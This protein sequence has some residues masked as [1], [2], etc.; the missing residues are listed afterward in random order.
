M[1]AH[2]GPTPRGLTHA[3][4]GGGN[5]V[6]QLDRPREIPRAVDAEVDMQ[7]IARVELEK[8]VLADGVRAND[9]VAVDQ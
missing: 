5:G 7:R 2:H 8:Q 9:C 4:T 6:V 3:T 1:L